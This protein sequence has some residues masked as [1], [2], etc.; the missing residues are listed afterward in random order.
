MSD[1]ERLLASRPDEVPGDVFDVLISDFGEFKDLMLSY[2][3][4]K[5]AETKAACSSSADS[6]A[7]GLGGSVAVRSSGLPPLAASGR[8]SLSLAGLAI[9]GSSLSP[10][11]ASAA[12]AGAS[13]AAGGAGSRLGG[14]LGS[15]SGSGLA[16]SGFGALPPPSPILAEPVGFFASGSR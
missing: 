7:A 16:I 14:Q 13:A 3:E 5:A 9:S 15:G 10:H 11:K 6:A 8:S 12:G 1:V 4:Q 2:K